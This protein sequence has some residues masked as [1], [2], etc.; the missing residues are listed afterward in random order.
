[1]KRYLVLVLA[2]FGLVIVAP[3]AFAT[4]VIF[5]PIPAIPGGPP[6]GTDCTLGDPPGVGTGLN[7]FTPCNV[8]KLNVEYAVTFVDCADISPQS[9]VTNAKNAYPGF[10]PISCLW[11][12]NVTGVAADT[13]MFD[14]TV[15][16][17][18]GG[19][20]LDC[21]S[22]PIALASSSC[23][24]NLPGDGD[25]FTLSFITNPPVASPSDFYL[26]IDLKMGPDP[27]GVTVSVPEPGVLG[28]FGFGLLALGV[29]FG[30]QRRRQTSRGNKTA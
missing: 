15:P 23:A 1:M 10:N 25:T 2:V 12:N 20:T 27:A 9:V 26:L 13:F 18:A 28:L 24:S 8:N 29:G 17:G 4:R 14:L 16:T 3:S 30:W 19:G 22:S 21:G 6:G 11:L 7:N 5:D